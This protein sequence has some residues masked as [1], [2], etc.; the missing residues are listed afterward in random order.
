MSKIVYDRLTRSYKVTGWK[1]EFKTRA[2]A[3]AAVRQKNMI[4]KWGGDATRANVSVV[5]TGEMYKWLTDKA[6]NERKRLSDIMRGLMQEAM[7]NDN[8]R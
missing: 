5:V 1:T 7:E 8:G 6:F 4:A 2:E 3:E